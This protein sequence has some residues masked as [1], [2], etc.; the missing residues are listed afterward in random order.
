[1]SS[2]EIFELPNFNKIDRFPKL[3]VATSNKKQYLIVRAFTSYLSSLYN[4]CV[5]N[6]LTRMIKNPSLGS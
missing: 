2:V 4:L 1:M 6:Q 5:I 3:A